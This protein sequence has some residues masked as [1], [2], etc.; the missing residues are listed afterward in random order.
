MAKRLSWVNAS[1]LRAFTFVLLLSMLL[2]A[3]GGSSTTSSSSSN[4]KVTL[5]F[6]TWL[7]LSS[8]TKVVQ[9]FEQTHPNIHVNISAVGQGPQQYTRLRAAFK[10]G[11]GAPD[12]AMLEY[13]YLPTFIATGKLLDLSAYNVGAI[14]N[15]Y[16]SWTWSQVTQGS[17]IYALPQ[18]SGPMALYYRQDILDQ[19]H[20]PVPQTWAQFAQEA[21]QLH[22]DNPKV[23]LINF[24]P[25][26]AGWFTSLTW[27]AGSQ[28]F[29]MNG[30]NLAVHTDDAGALK[31]ANFW[32]NLV[33]QKAVSTDPDFTTEFSTKLANGTYASWIAG[34][35]A[36]SFVASAA[37]ANGTGKWRVAPLPQWNVGD[38][39]Q[40]NWGG[41]VNAVTTYSQHPQQAIEFLRW[42]SDNSSSA[43]AQYAQIKLFPTL[44]SVY[45]DPAFTQPSAYFGN[46]NVNQVFESISQDV[47]TNFHWSPFQ[48]F[49]YQ[50]LND[51]LGSAVLGQI[52]FEQA[53]HNL[54][55]KTVAYA[56]QQGFTVSS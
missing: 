26:E 9:M 44:K 14:K 43:L 7:D 16:I 17:K 6:W 36:T 55:T 50:T 12:V 20:L 5:N 54:Q 56:Q 39:A 32:G 33:Q 29:N 40:S 46:Q 31:T 52:T 19:Y 42:F 21:V 30:S 10:A 48:D 35:W 3:C 22:K 4:E 2:A 11:S 53:L 49:V 47:N 13:Q 24:P 38:H 34:A 8:V 45:N 51:Q 15:D 1:V 18:D 25:N 28:P 27:Q 41:S 37:G 23:Y